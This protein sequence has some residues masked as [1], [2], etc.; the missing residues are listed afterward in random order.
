[1]FYRGGDAVERLLHRLVRKPDDVEPVQLPGGDIRLDRND[2]RGQY[3][4]LSSIHP[5]V[6]HALHI[7]TSIF[8]RCGRGGQSLPNKLQEYG[9]H[10]EVR[11]IRLYEFCG[12]Y[13]TYIAV[14]CPALALVGF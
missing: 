13:A 2:M 11:T 9:F 8:C 5:R 4:G 7:T 12:N 6:M 3:R 1:M 10:T 14:A